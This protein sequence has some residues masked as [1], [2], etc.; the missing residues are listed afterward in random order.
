MREEIAQVRKKIAN[1]N[2]TTRLD[3]KYA[4]PSSGHILYSP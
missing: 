1:R 2:K 4:F 3:R